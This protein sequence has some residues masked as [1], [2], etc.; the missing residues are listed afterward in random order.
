[1]ARDTIILFRSPEGMDRDNFN[2][3]MERLILLAEMIL[4]MIIA[5]D[6][7]FQFLVLRVRSI[8]FTKL[9]SEIYILLF[10]AD[11]LFCRTFNLT[12]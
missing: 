4:Y 9:V 6:T 1:M 2:R 10:I 12:S 5:E 11:A 3:L 8:F 7:V